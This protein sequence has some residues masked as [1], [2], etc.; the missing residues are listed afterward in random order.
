MARTYVRTAHIKA[1]FWCDPPLPTCCARGWGICSLLQTHGITTRLF[2]CKSHFTWTPVMLLA[3]LKF[4]IQVF[5]SIE[6]YLFNEF[7]EDFER[8]CSV[9]TL[10]SRDSEVQWQA[11]RKRW[12]SQWSELID[13]L[14]TLKVFCRDGSRCHTPYIEWF[15]RTN[16]TLHSYMQLKTTSTYQYDN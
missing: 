14:I 12:H 9:F 3:I 4:N 2:K 15:M 11:R 13:C 1:A 5:Q 10:Q 7:R 8:K 6:T 16:K